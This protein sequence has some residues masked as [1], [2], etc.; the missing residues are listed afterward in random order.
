MQHGHDMLR[1]RLKP[2][3][4]TPSS[5]DCMA[6]EHVARLR[7][8]F[9]MRCGVIALV[10][11]CQWRIAGSAAFIRLLVQH[12]DFR[13]GPCG[14][15]DCRTPARARPS[16][17]SRKKFISTGRARH[18]W[19]GTRPIIRRVVQFVV[20]PGA[21]RHSDQLTRHQPSQSPPAADADRARCR[22]RRHRYES[23]VRDA[24]VLL[25][26][27]FRAADARERARR[28]V[29][30]HLRAGARH[31]DQVRRARH[32]RRQPGRRRHPRAD[33]AGARPGGAAERRRAWPSGARS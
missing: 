23:A 24:G 30:H 6:L 8:L 26:F 2:I 27:A 14:R 17:E 21:C 5:A 7:K 32:A 18:D 11:R 29:A 10:D 20:D 1:R 12:G 4:S 13:T 22:L 33:G 25:R 28:A 16:Q 19:T 15:L 9:V 3:S 31:L